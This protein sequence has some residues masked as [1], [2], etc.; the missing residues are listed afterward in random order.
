MEQ[1]N[2]KKCLL[3]WIVNYIEKFNWSMLSSNPNAISL[4]EAN[5]DKIDWQHLSSNPN[6]IHLL[7]AN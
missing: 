3:P 7:E 5:E 4:L 6:A 2:M 1:S